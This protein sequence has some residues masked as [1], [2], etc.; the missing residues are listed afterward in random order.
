MI[1]FAIG[2]DIGG[3]KML[4]ALGDERGNLLAEMACSTHNVHG[5]EADVTALVEAVAAKAGLRPQNA[6][7]IGV[8]AP[9]PMDLATGTLLNPPNLGWGTVPLR[10]IILDHFGVPTM[11]TNDCKAAGFGEFRFGAGRGTQN[12]VYLG[13]GTGIGGCVIIGG[14]VYV[15]ATGNAGEVGHTVIALDGPLCSCGARGCL[16]AIAGGWAL[17][18]LGQEAAAASG[19]Q[20]LALVNGDVSAIT[21][22]H[23]AQ[24]AAQGDSIAQ[25]VLAYAIRGLGA[26][27]G[28]VMNA[29]GPERVVLGGGVVAKNGSDYVKRVEEA[30]RGFTLEGCGAPVVAA[31][32]G[33]RS[34]VLGALA[35]AWEQARTHK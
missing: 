5:G 12:M 35:H 10:Q 6:V 20:L 31:E 16:E 13:I 24:A 15:G 19:G 21:G 25:D 14:Q 33:E 9:G 22:A 3:T 17:G 8:G 26:G 29:F 18:R 7:T 11:L 23:V 4:A 27:V 28:N 32:L 1:Q 34:G 30:A 2:I